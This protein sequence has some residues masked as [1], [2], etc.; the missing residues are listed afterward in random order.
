MYIID[1]K[2]NSIYLE[3]SDFEKNESHKECC[4]R[5]FATD[6]KKMLF[7][8]LFES[9]DEDRKKKVCTCTVLDLCIQTNY[10]LDDKTQ[11]LVYEFFFKM[12]QSYTFKQDLTLSFSSNYHWAQKKQRS[13]SNMHGISAISV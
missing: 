8:A 13:G 11:A 2:L 12:F 5:F 9:L 6:D 1:Q 7:E 3:V 10:L 4:S